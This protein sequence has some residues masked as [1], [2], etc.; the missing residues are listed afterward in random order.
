M[1]KLAAVLFLAGIA[2]FGSISAA[3]DD[4]TTYPVP[5]QSKEE[6]RK[7]RCDRFL[8]YCIEKCNQ[9]IRRLCDRPACYNDCNQEYA[10]CLRD[11]EGH[12]D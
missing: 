12:D 2:I 7:K 11:A 6:A 10:R 3:A 5:Q 8:R 4:A 1:H 9:T